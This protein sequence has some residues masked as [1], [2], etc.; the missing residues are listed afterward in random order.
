MITQLATR[1]RKPGLARS[2]GVLVA[3][4]SGAV[5]GGLVAEHAPTWLPAVIL[6]P[7]AVVVIASITFEMAD[8]RAGPRRNR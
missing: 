5:G 8:T 3:I 1:D 6:T 7:L 4:V 2:V